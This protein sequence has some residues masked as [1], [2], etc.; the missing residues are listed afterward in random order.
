MKEQFEKDYPKFQAKI[1]NFV[2]AQNFTAKCEEY[3]EM[4]NQ[5]ASISPDDMKEYAQKS[6]DFLKARNRSLSLMERIVEIHNSLQELFALSE[7]ELGL[8]FD[9]SLQEV[10]KEIADIL[11]ESAYLLHKYE[12]ASQEGRK[13]I[14]LADNPFLAQAL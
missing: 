5:M 1:A 13:A 12:I 14:E 7:E 6:P 10:D 11:K 9:Y 3:M 4:F 2:L 8:K